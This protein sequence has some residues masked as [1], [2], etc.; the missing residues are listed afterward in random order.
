LKHT[1]E[2][3]MLSINI[4]R[5]HILK[6]NFINKLSRSVQPWYKNSIESSKFGILSLTNGVHTKFN[7]CQAVA[8]MQIWSWLWIN[9]WS[10]FPTVCQLPY[11]PGTIKLSEVS[12]K[13]VN[14]LRKQ[15]NLLVYFRLLCT[16]AQY[17]VLQ[18]PILSILHL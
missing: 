2:M 6:W 12:W 9:R 1:L 5:L 13:R 8:A 14:R 3:L 16:F 15:L 4:T 10:W 17:L 18:V 7:G 11:S